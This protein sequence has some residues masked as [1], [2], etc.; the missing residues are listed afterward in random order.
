[1]LRAASGAGRGVWWAPARKLRSV[2][3]V[4]AGAEIKWG[5]WAR[6]SGALEE[7]R[8]QSAVSS[9]NRGRDWAGNE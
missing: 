6:W 5:G 9:Q 4:K 7:S 8:W 3:L 2:W 1:V